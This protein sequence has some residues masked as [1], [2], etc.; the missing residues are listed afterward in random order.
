MTK[1]RITLVR[2]LGLPNAEWRRRLTYGEQ[3]EGTA[4]EVATQ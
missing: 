1:Y 4:Q 3:V 2:T